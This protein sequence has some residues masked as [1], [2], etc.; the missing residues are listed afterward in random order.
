MLTVRTLNRIIANVPEYKVFNTVAEMDAN[1]QK[2]AAEY[3]DRVSIS[4]IGKTRAGLPLYCLKIGSGSNNALLLGCPHPNEPIGAMML[5]YFSRALAEDP[6]LLKE[7][8]YTWYI[9]KSW[10]ADGTTLNEGWFKGP[11]TIYNYARNFYRPPGVQQVDWTFPID[12]KNVHFHSPIPETKAVMDLIEATRPVFNYTLHNAG[13]G[14][15]YYYISRP[16]EE[17]Y[18]ALRG[19]ANKNGVP[20][21]LGE[22]EAPYIE[23]YSPA[24]YRGLGMAEGYDYYEQYGVEHPETIMDTGTCSSD[25]AN[26]L[27]GTFTLLTELPYFY[28][29]RIDDLSPSDILRKDAVL[30]NLDASEKANLF[31]RATLD[32]IAPY[33]SPE[34]DFKKALDAFLKYEQGNDATRKMVNENPEYA[35]FATQ[36]EKFDNLL[37]SRFYKSLSLGLLTRASETELAKMKKSGENNAAKQEILTQAMLAAEDELKK[38]AEYLEANLNYEVVPI[39][40][41]VRIQLESGLITADILAK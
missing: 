38:L 11:F 34:N 37:I 39:Q 40:K 29:K 36:A 15:V 16:A 3:P 27:C 31:I 20:L 30:E 7:L 18:D 32:Q 1:S 4:E 14:G 6:A 21:N 28:D 26:S 13:F 35:N 2:L 23:R 41:L 9:I 10:D 25:F 22:P 24:V 12:Y 8:D 33:V 19:A 5:E 17:I